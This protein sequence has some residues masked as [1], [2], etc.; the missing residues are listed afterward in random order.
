MRGQPYLS[1]GMARLAK[2]RLDSFVATARG[3]IEE[4]ASGGEHRMATYLCKIMVRKN[5]TEINT[6][7][8]I[9]VYSN[10]NNDD[11]CNEG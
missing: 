11:D 10:K 4:S 5:I 3:E 8:N 7:N 6:N 2:T 1:I 9:I